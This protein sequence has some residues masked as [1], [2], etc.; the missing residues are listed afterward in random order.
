MT[1][2]NVIFMYMSSSGWK[3]PPCRNAPTIHKEH[4]FT[5]AV[6]CFQLCFPFCCSSCHQDIL[7]PALL[8]LLSPMTAPDGAKAPEKSQRGEK[9]A[10]LAEQRW[11]TDPGLCSLCWVRLCCDN[12]QSWWRQTYAAPS[13]PSLSCVFSNSLWSSVGF[14]GSWVH[15]CLTWAFGLASGMMLHFSLEEGTVSHQCWLIFKQRG[16]DHSCWV[17]EFYHNKITAVV[18]ACLERTGHTAVCKQQVA[19]LLIIARVTNDRD[20]SQY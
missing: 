12:L 17:C 3:L 4:Y 5:C 15:S 13:I 10:V 7:T 6:G 16:S 18:F 2:K 8:R 1:V 9:G 19:I 20:L 14:Q 11:D